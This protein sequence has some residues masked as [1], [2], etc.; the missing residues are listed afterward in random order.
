VGP[1]RD[2]AED[3]NP[4]GA[5]AFRRT[6]FDEAA[7]HGD[8][9]LGEVHRADPEVLGVLAGDE[10]VASIDPRTAV[11]LDIETTGL[12]GGAGTTPF[13]VCLG[14]F[15]GSGGYELW[16]GFLRDP[17]EEPAMLHEVARRVGAS[18]GVVS[19][20]GKSFDRHRLED[21]MRM[22]GVAPP[23]E[24]RPHLDLY[25]LC[26]RLYRPAFDD[27]RLQTMERGLCGV[28]REHDL[29]GAH[30]P[31]AWF[32]FL[33]GRPHLCE[34][35]FTHNLLDVL[36]LVTLHAHLGRTLLEQ[37][38]GGE[39]LD[40]ASGAAAADTARSRAASLGRL[41][42]RRREHGPALAWFDRARERGARDRQHDFLRAGCLARTGSPEAA[43]E[44][45]RAVGVA[46]DP[47]AARAL[48][49][50]ARLARGAE[51]RALL[52]RAGRLAE[53]CDARLAQ[54]IEKRLARL[55][56]QPKPG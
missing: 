16:Q 31:A 10:R 22:H 4:R 47:L 50:A 40:T 34:A 51:E 44:A 37:R 33:T 48:F 13:M 32:D 30:A 5:F 54:R 39:P 6:V 55:A 1:P 45:F 42:E 28:V 56:R 41:Y 25:H 38:A 24:G 36:S 46:R 26:R 19:F 15:T 35:V 43:V 11:Y 9:R 2:L 8:W 23:F 12:S 49:E 14:R 27:G 3:T 29:S 52:E 18:S 21:K 7:P 20:F 53:L 17:D